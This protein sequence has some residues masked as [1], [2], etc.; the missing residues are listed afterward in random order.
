[1]LPGVQ[2]IWRDLEI[3]VH[4]EEILRIGR[5]LREEMLGLVVDV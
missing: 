5:E 1:M 3:G 2:L 4:L